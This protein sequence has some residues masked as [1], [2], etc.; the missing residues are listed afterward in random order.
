MI[1]RHGSIAFISQMTTTPTTTIQTMSLIQTRMRHM[2]LYCS[3]ASTEVVS[4]RL[5]TSALALYRLQRHCD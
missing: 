2:I 5:P 3:Q 1:N 4:H